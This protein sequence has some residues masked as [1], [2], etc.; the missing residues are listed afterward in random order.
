M[1]PLN[2]NPVN[3]RPQT[4][5]PA[6]PKAAEKKGT[7][8][9]YVP[10]HGDNVTTSFRGVEFVANKPVSIS[11]PEHLEQLKLNPWFNVEGHNP[12]AIP[13][14]DDLVVP[15][16]S[17]GYRRYAI[18]WFKKVEKSAEMKERWESEEALR[19]KCGVGTDDLEYLNKLYGPR[20]AELKKAE[21]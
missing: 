10:R 15:T 13:V 12:A 21:G 3:P 5:L 2:Q 11:D 14:A 1:P 19:I 4:P 8:V 6:A 7:M 17:E 16:D 18:A 20:F 9:T